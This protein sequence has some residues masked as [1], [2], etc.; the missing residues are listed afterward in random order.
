MK[1]KPVTLELNKTYRRKRV[2][3]KAQETE[4]PP[5]FTHSGTPLKNPELEATIYLQKDL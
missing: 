1:Q 5:P 4:A 2:P 3:M